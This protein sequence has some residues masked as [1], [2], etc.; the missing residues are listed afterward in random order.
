M[1]LVLRVVK[2]LFLWQDASERLQKCHTLSSEQFRFLSDFSYFSV[3][4][5]ALDRL[6]RGGGE[7][8]RRREEGCMFDYCFLID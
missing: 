3:L 1:S 8:G 2:R 6:G 4:L 5:L 7:G